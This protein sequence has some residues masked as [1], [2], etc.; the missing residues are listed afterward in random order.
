MAPLN[1]ELQK[2]MG[3]VMSKLGLMLA[4]PNTYHAIVY[5]FSSAGIALKPELTHDIMVAGFGISG[6]IHAFISARSKL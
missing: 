1:A 5:L 3:K 6:A 4:N 2:R